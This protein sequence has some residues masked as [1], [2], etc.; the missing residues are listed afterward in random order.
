MSVRSGAG[1][2]D[3]AGHVGA[4]EFVSIKFDSRAQ[5]ALTYTVQV[6]LFERPKRGYIQTRNGYSPIRD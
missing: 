6:G 4:R 3:S 2:H 1:H 5:W